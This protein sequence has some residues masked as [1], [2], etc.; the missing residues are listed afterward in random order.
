MTG[1][2]TRAARNAI[3]RA[4]NTVHGAF[5]W[6]TPLDGHQ[7]HRASAAG[8]GLFYS[9]ATV[10]DGIRLTD[11]SGL[12]DARRAVFLADDGSVVR[13]YYVAGWND[14]EPGRPLYLHPFPVNPHRARRPDGRVIDVTDWA[15]GPSRAYHLKITREVSRR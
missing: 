12:R 5:R 13:P 6:W 1:D 14:R 7:P 11:L 8:E 4:G 2:E 9:T 10:A 3:T 15:V